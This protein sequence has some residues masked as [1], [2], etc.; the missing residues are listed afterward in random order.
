MQLERATNRTLRRRNRSVLLSTLFLDGPLTR[1]DL[2]RRTGLSQAA[3]SIVIAE[4]I[5]EGLVV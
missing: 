3:V 1:Q 5:D 2:A 4:L